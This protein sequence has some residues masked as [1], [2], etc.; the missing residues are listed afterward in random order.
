MHRL[1]LMLVCSTLPLSACGDRSAAAAPPTQGATHVDSILPRAEALRRFQASARPIDSLTGGAASRDAL[2]DAFVHAVETRDTAGL[3]RLSLDRDEFAFL[4]YP[5]AAQGLPPYDLAPDLLWFLLQ[6]GSDKGLTRALA[7]RG[8]R[9][10]GFQSYRCDTVPSREG[11]NLLWGPC[12]VRH[13]QAGAIVE[14]R[15][16]GLIVERDGRFKFVSYGNKL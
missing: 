7:S 16:F 10:L 1:L 15:L 9:T 11:A 3:R 13:R 14:E 2:V 12:V 6:T 4:Y 5:T 8:G